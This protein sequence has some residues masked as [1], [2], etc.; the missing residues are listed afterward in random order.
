M[1]DPHVAR[2]DPSHRHPRC[3]CQACALFQHTRHGSGRT[4]VRARPVDGTNRNR[5]DLRRLSSTGP[6]GPMQRVGSPF[7][8]EAP[9]RVVGG[10]R[11]GWAAADEGRLGVSAQGERT[12]PSR[13]LPSSR[14]WI[15]GTSSCRGRWEAGRRWPVQGRRESRSVPRGR[16]SLHFHLHCSGPRH[17]GGTIS[18]CRA[19]VITVGLH[20]GGG[21]VLKPVWEANKSQNDPEKSIAYTAHKVQGMAR[22]CTGRCAHECETRYLH[23]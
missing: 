20:F 18:N 12:R 15:L 10:R 14:S 21:C 22:A 2:D 19:F 11:G 6:A 1:G 9:L 4:N 16:R 5:T 3:P 23:P 8:Q 17:S 7:L 13:P